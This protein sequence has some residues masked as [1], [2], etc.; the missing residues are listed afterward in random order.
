M[1]RKLNYLPSQTSTAL[2]AILCSLSRMLSQLSIFSVRSLPSD[3]RLTNNSFSFKH[4]LNFPSKTRHPIQL[5]G[6][7]EYLHLIHRG[8]LLQLLEP[9]TSVL[10]DIKADRHYYW[11][12]TGEKGK[13]TLKYSPPTTPLH[14]TACCNPGWHST[15]VLPHAPPPSH[16]EQSLTQMC[17]KKVRT[18]LTTTTSMPMDFVKV[19]SLG[20]W[21]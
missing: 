16:N 6:L 14:Q 18:F 11:H 12:N 17:L 2:P 21:F 19:T 7:M 20:I 8:I 9:S 5:V 13:Q 10:P 4:I 15:S 1:T 3:L